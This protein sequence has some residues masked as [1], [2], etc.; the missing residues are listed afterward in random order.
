M[1]LTAIRPQQRE[2]GRLNIELDGEYAFSLQ[3]VLATRLTVGQELTETQIEQLRADDVIEKAYDRTLGYLS[4]RP[5]SADEIRR[6]LAKRSLEPAAI[7]QIVA[8]L[9]RARLVN[10]R[11]FAEFWVENR[12]TFRPRG[13]WA[14]RAELRQKGVADPVIEAALL[15]LDEH[16][17]AMRAAETAA[18]RYGRQDR[19]DFY[20]H[21]IGYLQRRGFP[22]VIARKVTEVYLEQNR[23]GQDSDDGA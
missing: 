6:Y 9:E 15:E 22:Y 3:S 18:R 21:M 12:E 14:L 10:D 13:A 20:R 19:D 7:D 17:S 23:L 1:K 16:E 5:R 8:R 4:Y 11:E 2:R